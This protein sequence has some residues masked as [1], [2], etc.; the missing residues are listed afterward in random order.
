M[1]KDDIVLVPVGLVLVSVVEGMEEGQLRVKRIQMGEVQV[2]YP[3][4]SNR[5]TLIDDFGE[6][7]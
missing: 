2:E 4:L 5:K 3:V 1:G 6:D 7:S